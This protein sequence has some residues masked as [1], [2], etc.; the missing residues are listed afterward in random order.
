MRVPGDAVT[1]DR[2]ADAEARRSRRR[3]RLPAYGPVE[4]ALGYWVFYVFVDRATPAVVEVLTDAL[5][6]APADVRFA[7]AAAL[8]FVLA[9]TVLGQALEQVAALRGEGDDAVPSEARAV[10]YLVVVLVGG[11]VAGWLFDRA[12]DTGIDVVRA[13]ATLDASGLSVLDVTLLVVFFLAFGAATRA[14][15]RL[16]IGGVRA[17]LSS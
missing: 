16:A 1:M 5:D 11:L 6:V 7:L 10:G 15:D 4:A 8:W 17:A 3:H 13:T 12:I 9:A 2:H 14:V